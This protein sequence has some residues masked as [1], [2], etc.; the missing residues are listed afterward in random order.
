L[1]LRKSAAMQRYSPLNS[2]IG[3]KGAVQV[4][5]EI[6]EFNPPPAMSSSGKPEPAFS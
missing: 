6:V 5:F 3:L 2:S 4:K 1:A